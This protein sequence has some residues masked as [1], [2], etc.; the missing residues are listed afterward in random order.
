MTS[1]QRAARLP[2]FKL[3]VMSI[4]LLV[5]RPG[6][7]LEPRTLPTPVQSE[8]IHRTFGLEECF[9]LPNVEPLAC[10]S[11]LSNWCVAPKIR[12]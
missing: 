3:L 7:R 10:A 2:N 1:G 6:R 5:L 12:A 8:A 4:D 9:A 11:S